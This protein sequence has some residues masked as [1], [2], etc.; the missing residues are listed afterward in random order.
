[1]LKVPRTADPLPQQSAEVVLP[2]MDKFN[3]QNEY[4]VFYDL[5]VYIGRVITNIG[6]MVHLKLQEHST[7]LQANKTNMLIE[8]SYSMEPFNFS[9]PDLCMINKQCRKLKSGTK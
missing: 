9:V 2:D 3:I 8:S 6:D 5:K 7:G 1:M 4:P